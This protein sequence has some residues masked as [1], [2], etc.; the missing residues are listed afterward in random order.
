MGPHLAVQKHHTNA[1]PSSVL[2]AVALTDIRIKTGMSPAR[3][4]MIPRSKR[5]PSA[6]IR[7][8][9]SVLK[10]N[11]RPGWL[12]TVDAEVVV[13]EEVVTAEVEDA[14]PADQQSII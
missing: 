11:T 6:S 4:A 10:T 13:A 5:M 1:A 9:A 2:A 7:P 14:G 12:S 3:T 8:F